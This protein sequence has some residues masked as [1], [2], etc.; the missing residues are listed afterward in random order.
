MN[1]LRKANRWLLGCGHIRKNDSTSIHTTPPLASISRCRF[2]VESPLTITWSR[3]LRCVSAQTSLI[4]TDRSLE[5][6]SYMHAK[7]RRYSSMVRLRGLPN[8][9]GM[10]LRCPRTNRGA[11]NTDWPSTVTSPRAGMASAAM[12]RRGVVLPAP[13]GPIRPNACPSSTRKLIRLTTTRMSN[14]LVTSSISTTALLKSDPVVCQVSVWSVFEPAVT[15]LDHSAYVSQF[16]QGI[17]IRY[18]PTLHR[19][20]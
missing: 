2:P 7:Y 8:S 1:F 10:N 13:F 4:R 9:T 3:P 5:G 6:I 20:H 16:R 15:F 18:S 12:S 14:D 19:K 11:E 17:R